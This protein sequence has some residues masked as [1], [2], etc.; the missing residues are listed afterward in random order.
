MAIEVVETS[1]IFLIGFSISR[2]EHK[3]RRE[4]K[5]EKEKEE[6]KELIVVRKKMKNTID[7]I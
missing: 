1:S 7:S 5:K 2:K 3:G 4:K 6:R